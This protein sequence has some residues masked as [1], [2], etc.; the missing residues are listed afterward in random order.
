MLKDLDQMIAHA[1][2]VVGLGENC[3]AYQNIRILY[4]GKEGECSTD[5]LHLSNTMFA[6]TSLVFTINQ[7]CVLPSP[8]TSL[9]VSSTTA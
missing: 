5:S 3:A 8:N 6:S 9:T 7:P 2:T 1:A 4:I